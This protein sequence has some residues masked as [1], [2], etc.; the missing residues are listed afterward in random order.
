MKAFC[1][2]CQEETEHAASVSGN[3]VVLTCPC[4]H[5]VKFPSAFSKE[6][7]AAFLEKHKA[8]NVRPV[9]DGEAEPD[10]AAVLEKFGL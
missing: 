4:G 10:A 1:A 9:V 3:D 8:C 5:F 7:M 2:K 6:E